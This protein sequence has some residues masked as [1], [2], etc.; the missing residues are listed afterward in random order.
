MISPIRHTRS[1][2]S[3]S[4]AAAARV[5]PAPSSPFQPA[6]PRP[7]PL[8]QETAFDPNEESPPKPLS[9][10]AIGMAIFFTVA[11]FLMLVL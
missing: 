6:H 5:H 11:A 8:S 9:I 10:I 1:S 3:S 7:R 2:S 4:T